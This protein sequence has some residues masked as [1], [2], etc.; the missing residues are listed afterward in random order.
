MRILY[1]SAYYNQGQETGANIRYRELGIALQ[2]LTSIDCVTS[3]KIAPIWSHHHQFVPIKRFGRFWASVVVSW[4]F[5][6]GNYDA[7][8]SD[9]VPCLPFRNV[10]YL[11]HDVR[12]FTNFRRHKG[13]ISNFAYLFN[14]RIQKNIITVS[15]YTK[16]E[17][18]KLGVSKDKI[19]VCHNGINL[20]DYKKNKEYTKDIDFIYIATFEER[21]NHKRLIDALSLYAKKN[22]NFRCV[23]IGADLGLLK[24]TKLQIHK[25]GLK[26]N[27][28]IIENCEYEELLDYYF[29]SRVFITPSL[30]EG[31]GMPI[32]EAE[33]AGLTIACSNIPVFREVA[34]DKCVFFDPQN[35]EDIYNSMCITIDH[36]K[37]I[38][39][40]E[41][42][43]K[44]FDWDDIA[45]N[46]LKKISS[47]VK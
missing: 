31:F 39:F 4:K 37:D 23:L 5:I 3:E 20:S 15:E 30:Y 33:A 9:L 13:V 42:R 6:S 10:F 29:R 43:I 35:V 41:T 47:K 12:Q 17:L 27:I 26:K 1:F 16:S 8:I 34:N 14:L 38:A 19:V 45:M 7:L 24:F 18:S 11:V 36:S 2:K 40:D 28:E 46:F 44:S 25:S 21:K 32:I 22:A